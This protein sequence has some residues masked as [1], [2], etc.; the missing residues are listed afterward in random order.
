[1]EDSARHLRFVLFLI[2]LI[3][4]QLVCLPPVPLVLR[5]YTVYH[6]NNGTIVETWRGATNVSSQGENTIFIYNGKQVILSGQ[7]KAVEE[8]SSNQIDEE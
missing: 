2:F 4:L 8:K 1:M 3:V 5:K 6:Y 7:V